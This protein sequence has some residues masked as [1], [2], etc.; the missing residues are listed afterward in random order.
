MQDAGAICKLIN[1]YA[2]RGRMLHRS[3]ESIYASLR[4][5]QVAKADGKVV[6]CVAADVFWSDLAEIKSLAVSPEHQGMGI[7]AA[8]VKAAIKDV[9]R[10][11]INRIFALTYERGFFEKMG[12]KVIRRD[13]LPEKVWRECIN[14][15]KA[16]HCDEIAMM[17]TPAG[18]QPQKNDK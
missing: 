4:E 17:L 8:L 15:P 2:E 10:L 11:G 1:Y 12:F 18:N 14:C 3:M 9:R 13:S 6:G 5:F 16:D 7:G